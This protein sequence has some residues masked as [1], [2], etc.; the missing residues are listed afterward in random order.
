GLDFSAA[1]T[2]DGPAFFVG[3]LMMILVAP[4]NFILPMVQAPMLI[5]LLLWAALFLAMGAFCYL[6]LPRFKGVL[7]NLQVRHRAEEAKFQSTGKHGSP[8]K[9]WKA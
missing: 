7:F 1:D 3:A 6:L 5:L 4:C 9:N 2:A 8:P